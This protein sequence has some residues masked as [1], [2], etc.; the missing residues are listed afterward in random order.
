[1]KKINVFLAVIAVAVSFCLVSCDLSE[2]V[3]ST[4][5]NPPTTGG[6]QAIILLSDG[7][8]NNEIQADTN[9]VYP[10]KKG[11]AVVIDGRRSQYNPDSVA[12]VQLCFISDCT[13]EWIRYRT[14]NVVGDTILVSLKIIYINGSTSTARLKLVVRDE[15][16]T[17]GDISFQGWS[18]FANGMRNN[19]YH[20]SQSRIYGDLSKPAYTGPFNNWQEWPINLSGTGV[21][22]IKDTAFDRTPLIFN[23]MGNRDSNN[24]SDATTSY[25]YYGSDNYYGISIVNGSA[26]KLSQMS[27][28]TLPGAGDSILRVFVR[29]DSVIATVNNRRIPNI[30]KNPNTVP[31]YRVKK[32]G[33]TWPGSAKNEA[34]WGSTGWGEAAMKMDT[35]ASWD[36]I[37]MLRYGQ[38]STLA[39]MTGCF[40][41]NAQEGCLMFYCIGTR[42]GQRGYTAPV[43]PGVKA[44]DMPRLYPN[45]VRWE[46]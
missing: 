4:P 1:M 10:V 41:W 35:A 3:S 14:F 40:A 5:T 21:F 44:E 22:I 8:G 30:K 29:N 7:F 32:S 38:G 25:Y 45:L 33:Q 24:W 19:T 27:P 17:D 6:P 16:G 42:P 9:R 23:Y 11:V 2:P 34:L 26:Y 12:T 37:V 20:L 46:E 31:S 15:A 39:D 43:I 18:L 36:H 28:L 13:A